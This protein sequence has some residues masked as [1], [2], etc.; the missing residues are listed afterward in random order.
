VTALFAPVCSISPTK[1]RRY[2]WAAWWTAP[3][4]EEPFRKPDA[5]QGGARTRDEAK[6]EAEKAA[7]RSL[8]EIEPRWARAW[9]RVLIGEAPWSDR[10]GRKDHPAEIPNAS[11]WSVLGIT[12]KATDAEIKRAFRQRA[13]E[14]H[15]DHGGD[16]E[17]F[18]AVKEAYE[19]A[20][21]RRKKLAVRP[22]AKR[23]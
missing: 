10:K 16:A 7:G 20:I 21:L 1:R 4:S 9:T 22:K 12:A 13:L 23:R 15:P 19:K 5:S 18:R 17:A 8:V 6:R 3:P 11:V 2:L 14:T